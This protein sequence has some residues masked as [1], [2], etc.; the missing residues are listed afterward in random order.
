LEL[1][2]VL[3][4]EQVLRLLRE[5]EILKLWLGIDKGAVEYKAFKDKTPL[6]V[7]NLLNIIS[8]D[9]DIISAKELSPSYVF[10]ETMRIYEDFDE[11]LIKLKME[12]TTTPPAKNQESTPQD[13]YNTA[14]QLLNSIKKLM[15][16]AGLKSIDVYA[17]ERKDATPSDV[18]ELTQIILAELQ[19]I[20]AFVG[21]NHTITRGAK[22]YENKTPADARQMLEWL[23][24]KSDKIKS[25]T[26]K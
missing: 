9:F 6:D 12:D 14:I 15:V 4:Y 23:L 22:R 2:P 21:L 18:F 11:I 10:S 16:N 17:F 3:T 26:E 8:R 24:I 7:Y 25:L 20:K 1:D 19:V 13:T 5:V